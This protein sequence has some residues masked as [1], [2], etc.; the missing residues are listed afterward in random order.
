[1]QMRCVSL[2]LLC[3][4]PAA[5]LGCVSSGT[6]RMEAQLSPTSG[7]SGLKAGDRLRVTVYGEDRLTGEYEVSETGDVS[8]PL[9]GRLSATDQTQEQ[10]Q[11][12]LTAALRKAY[13]KDPHVTVATLSVRPFYILGEV[14]KPGE[15][16]YRSGL[17]IWRAMAVAGGQT[18][19]ASG[20]TVAI[21]RAGESEFHDYQLASDVAVGPGD[22]VRVPERWF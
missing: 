10:F 6:K 8:L 5:L 11:A 21:Q 1:M 3:L 12:S 19:R 14:E 22:V 9:V 17:D 7:G 2:L 4:L 18:Y 16:P 13:L 15:Y 20:S